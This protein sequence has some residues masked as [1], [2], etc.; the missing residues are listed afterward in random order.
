MYTGTASQSGKGSVSRT[1][2]MPQIPPPPPLDSRAVVAPPLT[3]AVS[4]NLAVQTTRS[5]SAPP[6]FRSFLL[7]FFGLIF[8]FR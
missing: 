4:G 3:I 5:L 1:G 7:F 2:Q 8:L 6:A